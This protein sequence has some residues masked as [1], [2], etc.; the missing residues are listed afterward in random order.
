MLSHGHVLGLGTDD[1]RGDYNYTNFQELIT[2]R[3]LVVRVLGVQRFD[4]F[5]EMIR[6]VCM[7]D[8]LPDI[9]LSISAAAAE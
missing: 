2:G 8:L 7:H 9:E 4:S 3:R 1:T 5:D 6:Q